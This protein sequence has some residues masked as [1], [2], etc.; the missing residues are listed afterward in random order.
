[1]LYI[2]HYIKT[3]HFWLKYNG[4]ANVRRTTKLIEGGH[5][6]FKIQSRDFLRFL[7]CFVVRTFSRT[8]IYR[9]P[10]WSSCSRWLCDGTLDTK[11]RLEIQQSLQCAETQSI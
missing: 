8:M 1:M 11:L 10:K 2:Q 9:H 5:R 3:I 6:G 7:P 4:L